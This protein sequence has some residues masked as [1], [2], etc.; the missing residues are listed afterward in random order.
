M[1]VSWEPCVLRVSSLRRG[2]NIVLVERLYGDLGKERRRGIVEVFA[3]RV[4][5]VS[6]TGF[7]TS[8]V[9]YLQAGWS[10]Q[11]EIERQLE[12]RTVPNL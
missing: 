10:M 11:I 1:M 6:R 4:V 12:A 9:P 7:L 3:S 2:W 8:Q 5:S